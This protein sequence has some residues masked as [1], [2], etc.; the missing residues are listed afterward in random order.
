MSYSQTPH[1]TYPK[2]KKLDTMICLT[3]T[4]AKLL[5]KSLIYKNY[6]IDSLSAQTSIIPLQSDLIGLQSKEIQNLNTTTLKLNESLKSQANKNK[7]IS[8]I[9]TISVIT[10]IILFTLLIK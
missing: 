1:Y 4:N 2:F 10:N 5:Y 8:T 6:T 3:P 9:T 7:L